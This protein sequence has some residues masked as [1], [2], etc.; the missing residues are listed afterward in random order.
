[1]TKLFKIYYT[2]ILGSFPKLRKATISFVT[3][4]CPPARRPHAKTRLPLNGF[5]LNLIFDYFSK[6]CRENS[7]FVKILEE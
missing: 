1:V 4:K 7:S 2:Y 5:S 6:I 3:S